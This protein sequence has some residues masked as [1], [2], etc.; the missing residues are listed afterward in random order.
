[1]RLASIA[2][3]SLASALQADYVSM[4][5]ESGNV[6]AFPDTTTYRIFATFDD[7]GDKVLALSGLPPA[8]PLEFVSSGGQLVQDHPLGDFGCNS[9]SI[10][11]NVLTGP[12]DSFLTIRSFE[13]F[14]PFP[15][16]G[17]PIGPAENPDIVFV[18]EVL[19]NATPIVPVAG[20]S[21]STGEGAGGIFS[22]NPSG[23]EE[24]GQ[25]VLIAQFTLATDD[26]FT[27]SG[28]VNYTQAKTGDSLVAFFSIDSSLIS[29]I[30]GCDTVDGFLSVLNS[31]TATDCN[32]N[33]VLDL[34]EAGDLNANGLAD[35]CECIADVNG[36]DRVDLEDI[37]TLLF[38]WG[39][40]VDGSSAVNV[41]ASTA[42]SENTIDQA[43]LDAVMD[44]ALGSGCSP[45]ISP[46]VGKSSAPVSET[47]EGV[48]RD[49]ALSDA[50]A[51]DI[52]RVIDVSVEPVVVPARARVQAVSDERGNGQ[53]VQDS[54]GDTEL[55]KGQ[56]Q[57]DD[58]VQTFFDIIA[59]SS[60]S[61]F[62]H[63]WDLDRDGLLDPWTIMVLPVERWPEELRPFA[64]ILRP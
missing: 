3:M 57:R 48:A 32:N 49:S 19:C 1:M 63:D 29:S 6:P 25:A 22:N 18:P 31:G 26:D 51:I 59:S 27:F 34:C 61:T 45:E 39:E 16:I 54:K 37:V 4:F 55:S 30:P 53:N 44:A 20:S 33:N 9:E 50:I 64:A 15:A 13:S 38:A 47:R 11:T 24:T 36:D 60:E 58:V 52:A 41:D 7:P 2:T 17:E 40:S 21:W 14:A 5:V 8:F 10:L 43:D 56:P 46:F 35:N 12:A 42:G 28:T 62:S 23:D